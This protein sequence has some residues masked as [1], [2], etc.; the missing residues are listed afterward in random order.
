MEE[1]KRNWHLPG[2]SLRHKIFII[3][4]CYIVGILAM[5]YISQ[6]DLV[7]AKEKLEVVELAYSLNSIILEVRRYE[8][9][10]FLYDTEEALQENKKQLQLAYTTV[11]KISNLVSKFKVQPML[12]QLGDLIIAYQ[13]DMEELEKGGK[14]KQAAGIAWSE[15]IRG[16]GQEMTELSE[17][18]VLFEHTQIRTILE[19]LV[20]QLWGWSLLAI[21]VGVF[22]PIVVS[23]TIFKPLLIIKEAARDIAQGRFSKIEVLNTRDEMQQV[24][25]A[26]NTMVRELEKRQDQLVQSQKLSSIGTLAAG[27][28]H[29]LNNPLNNIST[30]CQIAM[31]EFDGGDPEFLQRML[32]NVDQ[33]TNRARDVVQGL[34]EFSRE[35]EFERRP[36][37]LATVVGRAVSLVN[38]QVPSLIELSVSV[39]E[40]LVLPMDTQRMQEVFLNLIINA[41]Q[42]ISGSGSIRISAEILAETD[43]VLICVRDTGPGIDPQIQDRL[44]DPFF[45]TKEEGQGT[46]LGLSITYG[47]IQKH[48]GS[49]SVESKPGEGA[50]FSIRLPLHSASGGELA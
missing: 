20:Q 27:I 25:E 42:A 15:R 49:I 34:L 26:F 45:S 40:D 41:S 13:N 21:T 29:Q 31:S 16:H 10:F 5:T 23:F 14:N 18:L 3:L 12:Q 37:A 24:M 48:E 11:G 6:E 17:K 46:G 1:T 38:S 35:R 2:L 8:K 4:G 30:S 9:N 43:E 39:P 7:T 44:F 28:A 47:I 22:M 36:A 19:E 50:L 33:E 32:H